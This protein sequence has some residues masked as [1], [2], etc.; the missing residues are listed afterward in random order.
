MNKLTWTSM[1]IKKLNTQLWIY[2]SE[3]WTSKYKNPWWVWRLNYYIK[4]IK[5]TKPSGKIEKHNNSIFFFLPLL[6]ESK[7]HAQTMSTEARFLWCYFV[8]LCRRKNSLKSTRYHTYMCI[9][10]YGNFY[11]YSLKKINLTKIIN[12]IF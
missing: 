4:N 3:L 9:W 12:Y 8:N 10:Y 1:L 6:K 7:N 2:N 11:N 5:F